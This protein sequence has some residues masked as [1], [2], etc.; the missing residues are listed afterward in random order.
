MNSYKDWGNFSF[1]SSAENG[2]EKHFG[3]EFSLNLFP[4]LRFKSKKRKKKKYLEFYR[5]GQSDTTSWALTFVR[6][7][8][9]PW[10]LKGYIEIDKETHISVTFDFQRKSYWYFV[11]CY[12]NQCN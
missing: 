11:S 8:L 4:P 5:Y 6:D 2:K 10:H 9:F 7:E 3:K 1:I 12:G